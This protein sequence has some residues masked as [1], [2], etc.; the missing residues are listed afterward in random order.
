MLL[1]AQPL[2]SCFFTVKLD[3]DISPRPPGLRGFWGRILFLGALHP[4]QPRRAD[5]IRLQPAK[6]NTGPSP[7]GN[8]SASRY[9]RQRPYIQV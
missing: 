2:G 6:W 7:G 8:L 5:R 3:V 9:W 1:I 4:L